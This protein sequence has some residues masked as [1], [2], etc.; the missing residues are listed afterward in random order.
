MIMRTKFTFRN[1]PHNFSSSVNKT[2]PS[3]EHG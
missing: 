3:E 1:F 2:A